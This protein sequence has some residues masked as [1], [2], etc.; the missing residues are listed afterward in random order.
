MSIIPNSAN[1]LQPYEV[2]DKFLLA[3]EAK[4]IVCTTNITADGKLQRFHIN[5]DKPRSRN[6]WAVL[7]TAP[8]AGAFGCWKRGVNEKWK[9]IGQRNWTT[10]EWNQHWAN[11]ETA[12]K[13]RLAEKDKVQA[14][15][16]K[17]AQ[18]I[19]NKAVIEDGRHPYI[20]HKGI[21]PFGVRRDRDSLVVPLYDGKGTLHGLQFIDSHAKRFLA[22]SA[23]TGHYFSIIGQ[24]DNIILICEGYATG[25]SIHEA[26]GLTVIVAFDAGNLLPVGLNI[27]NAFPVQKII[28]C[29]DND[30]GNEINIGRI[31]AQE[32]AAEI[33][34]DAI[35]PTFDNLSQKPTD[36]NDLHR[37]EGLEVVK[38]QLLGG[39]HV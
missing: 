12:S 6:G 21:K 5:G 32:A 31:K 19:W 34:G 22:G 38:S 14:K 18:A 4:G 25:A 28:I 24:Q 36:F 11:M 20:L 9:P 16:R 1:T 7:F 3:M 33:N 35:V 10:E 39:C 23:K 30:I 27:R 13:A 26:T 15:C 17:K 8:L 29:A 37:L 2:T